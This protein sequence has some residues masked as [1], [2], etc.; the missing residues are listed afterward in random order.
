MRFLQTDGKWNSKKDDYLF[1]IESDHT[2]N[3]GNIKYYDLE[4][5]WLSGDTSRGVFYEVLTV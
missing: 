3:H 4:E 2:D 5:G 1:F